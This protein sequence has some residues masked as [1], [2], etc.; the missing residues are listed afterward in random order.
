MTKHLAIFLRKLWD[1]IVSP[2]VDCL[3]TT[4]PPQSE[5]RIWWSPTGKFSELPLHAAGPF[6]KGQRNLPDLYI[7]SYTPTLT[8]LIRA[9]RHDPSNSATEPKRFIAIVK[10]KLLTRPNS[11]P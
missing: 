5:S 3:Q 9:K 8:A 10:P 11:L 4:H 2:I 6:R 1:Q 7:S